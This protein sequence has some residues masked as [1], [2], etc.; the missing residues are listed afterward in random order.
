MGRLI[1]AVGPMLKSFLT[2]ALN[3]GMRRGEILSL[4]WQDIDFLKGFIDIKDS[5]S[6]KSRKAPMNIFVFE[7][8]KGMNQTSEFV[9]FNPETKE[10]IKD[11]KTA[12]KAACARAR[13]KGLRIHDLRHTAATKMIEAGVDLVTVSK[14]LGHSSIAMTMRYCNPGAETAKKAVDKLAEIYA[15]TR[16]K[17]DMVEIPKPIS[18]LKTDN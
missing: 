3:T 9:F 10:H 16:Q 7:A 2:I 1:E 8:L 17:V 4:K 6:G 11:V 5:K 18:Y 15:Q 13:I 14:L 12:F